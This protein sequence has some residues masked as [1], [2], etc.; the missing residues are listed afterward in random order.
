METLERTNHGHLFKQEHDRP[1]G[2]AGARTRR[3]RHE[4]KDAA[5]DQAAGRVRSLDHL[6]QRNVICRLPTLRAAAKTSIFFLKVLPMLP[7]RPVDWMMT[8][9]LVEGARY[10]TP[11]GETEGDL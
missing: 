10:P 8:A 4:A 9:P 11:R 2:L 3:L 1:E 7:S 6:G 5:R